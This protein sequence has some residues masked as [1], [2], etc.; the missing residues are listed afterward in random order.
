[1]SKKFDR[2]YITD[3]STAAMFDFLKEIY[4][5]PTR[6]K[7]LTKMVMEFRDMGENLNYQR[8]KIESLETKV[9]ILEREL[10]TKNSRK[11]GNAQTAINF[12][13]TKK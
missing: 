1:M 4:H 12:V 10:R 3:E 7:F 13:P 11:Y 9:K 5:C 2:I 6:S 8:R